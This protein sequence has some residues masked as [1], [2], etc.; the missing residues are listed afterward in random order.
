MMRV[1]HWLTIPGDLLTNNCSNNVINYPYKNILGFAKG[2]KK[3]ILNA[4]HEVVLKRANSNYKAFVVAFKRFFQL[5]LI[6]C[7]GEFY[8]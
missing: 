5:K 8:V 1:Q 6:G 7:N 4:K 3:C 2:Y